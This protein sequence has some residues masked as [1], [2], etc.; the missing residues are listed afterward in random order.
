VPE[1]AT[2]PIAVEPGKIVL[3]PSGDGWLRTRSADVEDGTWEVV[4]V[5]GIS[6]Q[7]DLE[8]QLLRHRQAASSQ[9]AGL[10]QALVAEI[11]SRGAIGIR[12]NVGHAQR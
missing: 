1:D 3:L 4:I 12:F 11:R 10:D 6:R 8:D 5:A 9:R 7:G 2:R